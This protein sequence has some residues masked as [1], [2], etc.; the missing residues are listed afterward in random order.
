MGMPSQQNESAPGGRDRARPTG[1]RNRGWG[2]EEALWKQPE[3]LQSILDSMTDAVA[4]A[5]LDERL[6]MFNRAAEQMFGLATD[7]S[8]DDWSLHYG[9]YR[10]DTVTLYPAD[11]LPLRRAIRGEE[12]KDV[13]MFVRRHSETEGFWI[14]INGG[15]LR[16]AQGGL[17][18]GVVVCR[19]ISDRYRAALALQRSADELA[20]SNAQLRRL[21]EDLEEVGLSRQKAY[22]ELERAYHDLKRAEAQLI[23]AEK[24]SALGQ[25]IA[26]V[27]HEIN[28]PLAYVANNV[29][30]LR[31]DARALHELVLIHQQGMDTLAAHHPEL[32]AQI[33]ELCDRIDINY[34]LDGLEN[35]LCRSSDGLQRIQQIVRDL[36]DFARLDET[37]RF[38]VDLN[39][40]IRSTV[41]IIAGHAKKQGVALVV[42][43]GVLP[44]L[45]CYPGKI[46][47]VV[48]NLLAN[49]IDA[50]DPGGQVTLQT[51]E[52]AAADPPDETVVAAGPGGIEIHVSDDGRG[53]PPEIRDRIF[54]AFFTTKPQGKGTGL[55][56]S[57]SAGIVHAHQG[58]IDVESTPGQ[59]TRFSVFLPRG[60]RETPLIPLPSR[61]SDGF[62]LEE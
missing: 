48:M 33:D 60:H 8:A 42:E 20:C 49:A 54:D 51:R 47:Q 15:P 52:T 43:L 5:D 21:T 61:R 62:P 37:D 32:H 13:E 22:Q 12:V 27:A 31:R 57:I 16:D 53:I 50:C 55:G 44:P 58:R 2:T 35:L 39:E 14:L 45:L 28:N 19:D 4:V 36:R 56:L 29:A 30:I 38:L 1:G 3:V 25:L 41:N 46:N 17:R 59:G 10:A 40:G 9:L 34:T 7:T 26:G 18:G 24:L 23:Q 6:V 11:E